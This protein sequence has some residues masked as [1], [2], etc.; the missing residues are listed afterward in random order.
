MRELIGTPLRT[1]T[2]PL[3]AEYTNSAHGWDE[4]VEREFRYFLPRYLDLVSHGDP[5][6]HLGLDVCLRRLADAHWHDLWAPREARFLN[7]WF[8]EL[9]VHHLAEAKVVRSGRG[10]T[11]PDFEIV[12]LLTLAVRSGAPL[13]PLLE[14]WKGDLRPQAC[15]HV[16]GLLNDLRADHRGWRPSNPF[17]D[18]CPIEAHRIGQFVREPAWKPRLEAAFFLLDGPMQQQLVSD[19]IGIAL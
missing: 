12:D 17:L 13:E 8:R 16:A 4:R 9:F 18:S 11:V 3:L 10:H 19:A 2:A 7:I 14:A 15:V 6:D 5:P 1:I